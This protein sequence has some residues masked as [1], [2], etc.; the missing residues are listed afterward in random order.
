M[1]PS[2]IVNTNN[3]TKYNIDDWGREK[4]NDT[5]QTTECAGPQVLLQIIKQQ[6]D[7]YSKLH[8]LFRSSKPR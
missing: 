1:D 5:C 7:D 2:I 4:R 8:H 3:L 6:Y